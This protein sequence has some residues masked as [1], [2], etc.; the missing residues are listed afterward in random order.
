MKESVLRDKSE[1]FTT[2]IINMHKY[3]CK[4]KKEFTISKQV[5]RSGTSIGANIAEA[6]S[7]FTKKDFV[8][9]LG[10]SLKEC[11]ETRHWLKS[12]RNAE[13]LSEKEFESIYNDCLEIGRMLNSSIITAKN[14]LEKENKKQ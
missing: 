9:K 6:G 7:A 8:C 10:I 13:F 4:E 3:L 2:R 5:L 11:A 12:L 14:N 1:T